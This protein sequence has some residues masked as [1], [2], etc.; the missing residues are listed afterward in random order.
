[1]SDFFIFGTVYVKPRKTKKMKTLFFLAIVGLAAACGTAKETDPIVVEE[2]IEEVIEEVES[3][4]P[5]TDPV[6]RVFGIVHLN[7]GCGA[8]IEVI[9][10][11]NTQLLYP[12]NLDEAYKV[13]GTRIKF[14]Y[15]MSRAMQP[16]GCSVDMTVTVTDVTRMRE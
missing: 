11:E 5:P 7:E 1:M 10:G 3:E 9:D 16:E 12:I 4:E 2:V 13:E 8:Y 15:A 6:N 14:V